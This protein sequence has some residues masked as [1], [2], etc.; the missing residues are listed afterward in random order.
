MQLWMLW[1]YTFPGGCPD[2]NP[3]SIS[4]W[5]FAWS[6]LT[7]LTFGLRTCYSQ[8]PDK[9][10]SE[11]TQIPSMVWRE[12]ARHLSHSRS[13]TSSVNS[14]CVNFFGSQ[15]TLLTCAELTDN[16]NS[17]GF[18]NKRQRHTVPSSFTHAFWTQGQNLTFVPIKF[19][20]V[21]PSSSLYPVKN[22]WSPY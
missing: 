13:Y 18:S 2:P 22:A 3:S 20:L 4:H 11:R 21:K 8:L 10:S 16:S 19:Y 9:W 15:I 5:A 12:Y 1:N 17:L 6:P 14:D 7:N